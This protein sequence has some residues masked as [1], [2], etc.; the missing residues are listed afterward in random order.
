[1]S[2]DF[3]TDAEFQEQLDWIREF[4]ADEIDPLEYIVPH[5]YDMADPVRRS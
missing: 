4:V 2:W 3:E 1:M 5:P